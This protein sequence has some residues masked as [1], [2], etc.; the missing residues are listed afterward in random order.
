V[1]RWSARQRGSVGDDAHRPEGVAMIIIHCE[2]GEGEDVRVDGYSLVGA[3]LVGLN[4][5]RAVL[6]G[7]DLRRADL[8]GADLRSAWLEGAN[9]EQA[10]LTRAQLPACN[11][12]RANFV[13]ANPL[14]SVHAMRH[15]RGGR[16]H[17]SRPEKSDRR[18]VLLRRSPP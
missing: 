2:T 3:A 7:Q 17:R 4:L 13:Q 15:L 6:D 9:L 12:S 10:N 16:F 11:A 8:S 18:A 1:G 5:H 14:R